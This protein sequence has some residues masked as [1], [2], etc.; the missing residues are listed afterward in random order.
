MINLEGYNLTPSEAVVECHMQRGTIIKHHGSWVLRY[1]DAEIRGGLT[2]RKKAFKLLAPISPDYPN[3]RSVL[4]LAEKI[5]SPINSGSIQAESAIRVVDFI[6]NVYLPFVKI[7]LR[8]STYKDYK[9]DCFEKHLK[10]RLADVRIRDFRTVTGQRII[11]AIARDNS[12]VGHKTLMRIKSFLS[13]T[14]KHAKREGLIDSENPMRDVSVP[15]RPVKFKG[16]IYSMSEIEQIA[17]CVGAVD[18]RAFAVVSVAAFAGL[19]MSELRGLRW[20]DFNGE[21]LKISRSVWRTHVGATKTPS[22]QE[23]VP[24]LPILKKVLDEYR[25]RVNGKD[26]DYMFAGERRGAPLNLANL[27]NR[28]IKPA[29]AKNEQGLLKWKGWHAFRR[30]LATNLYSCGVAPKVIQAILRHSDIGT[31][32]QYYVSTPDAESREALQKIEDWLAVV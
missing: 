8:P 7:E 9:K 19:R 26:G 10:S 16:E 11:A 4:L 1:S 18:M 31:T 25:V 27:A 2:H 24:V 29:L 22:S 28:V 3:K 17:E 21:S 6:E 32:L 13:G 20:A 30:S 23:S 14:F 5:L 12:D 15:G